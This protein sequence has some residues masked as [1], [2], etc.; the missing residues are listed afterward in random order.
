MKWTEAADGTYKPFIQPVYLFHFQND[1]STMLKDRQKQNTPRM[2]SQL[3]PV[4]RE[5]S[6]RDAW[7]TVVRFR[8]WNREVTPLKCL[9]AVSDSRDD[10]SNFSVVSGTHAKRFTISDDRNLSAKKPAIR[11]DKMAK[12]VIETKEKKHKETQPP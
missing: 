3:R 9:N 12:N 5:T 10:I 11:P 6:A 8:V 1:T 7:N 4:L 2:I